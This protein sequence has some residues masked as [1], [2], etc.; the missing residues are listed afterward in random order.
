M[1]KIVIIDDEENARKALAGIIE[2]FF[3]EEAVISGT[4]DR[5]K[6]GIELIKTVDP[7]I[8]FLDI[9]MPDGTGFD[10]LEKLPEHPFSLVFATGHNDFALKAFKFNA[11]DYILKPVDIQDVVKATKRAMQMRPVENNERIIQQL[12]QSVKKRE[13]KK[14]ILKTSEDIH[15]VNVEDIVRCESDGGY[16]T[17]F[18]E[19]GKSILVS[20]NLKEYENILQTYGFMRTHNSHLVNLNFVERYGKSAGGV[21]Y[22]KD[23]TQI[24]VSVRKKEAVLYAVENL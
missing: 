9:E 23:G 20:K 12:L 17:F 8:V 16:T 24:P 6:S 13:N 15:V 22:L 4:A 7:D 2:K 3:S 5:V 21:L 14:L 19:G 18:V 1:Y 11:V 10:I